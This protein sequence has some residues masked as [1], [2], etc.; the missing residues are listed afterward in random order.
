MSE[1]LQLAL[2]L[3]DCDEVSFEFCVGGTGAFPVVSSLAF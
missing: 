1:E 3:D 2:P